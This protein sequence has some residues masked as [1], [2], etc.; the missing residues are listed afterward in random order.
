GRHFRAEAEG[1]AKVLQIRLA[2]GVGVCGKG[3]H[4]LGLP[5]PVKNAIMWMS[6][7]APSTLRPRTRVPSRT[8]ATFR[9]RARARVLLAYTASD[10]LSNPA[11][12]AASS[13][14]RIRRSPSPVPR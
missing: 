11:G 10:T 8:N 9:Q 14:V 1:E 7:Y 5:W 2:D 6:S 4:A 12:V 13:A 3:I